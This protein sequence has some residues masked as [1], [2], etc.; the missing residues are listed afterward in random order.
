MVLTAD[1]GDITSKDFLDEAF[2]NAGEWCNENHTL[3]L[4]GLEDYNYNIFSYAIDNSR[5]G[6]DMRLDKMQK[7]IIRVSTTILNWYKEREAHHAVESVPRRY[8][9]VIDLLGSVE[10]RQIIGATEIDPQSRFIN[11]ITEFIL[12]NNRF[13]FEHYPYPANLPHPQAHM[14]ENANRQERG[15]NLWPESFSLRPS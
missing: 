4:K 5:A 15:L 3:Y 7:G 13:V 12:Y 6:H 11:Q 14:I 9:R 2:S 8:G 1:V 10:R